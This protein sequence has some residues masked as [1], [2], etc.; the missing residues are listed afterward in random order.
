MHRLEISADLG[1][2]ETYA[3]LLA[4]LRAAGR[5]AP[6]PRWAILIGNIEGVLGWQR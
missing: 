6:D 5:R 2:P 1:K 4:S 3:E